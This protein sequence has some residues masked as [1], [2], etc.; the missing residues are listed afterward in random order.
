VICGTLPRM[1]ERRLTNSERRLRRITAE[2]PELVRRGILEL[3][4]EEETEEIAEDAPLVR[5]GEDPLA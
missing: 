5:E 1:S 4:R 3:F 2:E